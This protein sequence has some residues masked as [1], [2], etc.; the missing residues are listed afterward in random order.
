M[1]VLRTPDDRFAGLADYPFAPHYQEVGT[2]D[3]TV[4]RMH[5]LDE[6]PPGAPPVLLL[7]GNPSWSYLYRHIVAGLAARGHRVLAPDLVGMGRSDKPDDPDFFTLARHVA[8]LAQWLEALDVRD[9]TMVCHD[10]GGIIGLNVLPLLGDRVARV[11][12]AN[13]GLPAGEGVNP[14]MER[15]LA[16]SQS[17][18]V[19][20]VGALVDGG[21]TRR[22]R[23]EERAA[24]DA[25]F[26]DGRYQAAAKRFPLLIPLQPD[27]PGVPQCRETWAFL[28][29]W[30][31][32][33]LTVF[34]SEDEIA[35]KP[36]S[37]RKLQ[38]RVPGARGLDHVV[39]EGAGHFLQEDAPDR[40][41]DVIDDFTT[42]GGR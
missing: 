27:N 37:H 21:T 17:V 16:F 28:D 41:V 40:L 4:V 5:H 23:P 12:A 18:E 20:P 31:K 3:G 13:T 22:L 14:F 42:V 11:A 30:T 24:Y 10:W 36:G 35:Y 32:P 15:W 8:W 26:P 1:E 25:P 38:R 29:T 6:G 34:G 39:I 9:A 19:L 2:D 7:H 33:L